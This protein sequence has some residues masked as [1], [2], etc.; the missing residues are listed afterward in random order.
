MTT[1]RCTQAFADLFNTNASIVRDLAKAVAEAAPEANTLVI[2]NP[3]HAQYLYTLLAANLVLGQFHRPY[4]RRNL[5]V[6]RDLQSQ[7]LV[8]GH[9]T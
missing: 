8:R 6:E 4:L 9:H 3:V 1:H 5:Q 2:S 7:A